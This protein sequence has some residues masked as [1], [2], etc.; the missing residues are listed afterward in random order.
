MVAKAERLAAN[1]IV[2]LIRADS[3]VESALDKIFRRHGLTGP[4][5]NVL[6]I[7]EGAHGPLSPYEIGDRLL[8]TRGTVTGL[9][10][11]LEGQG[12][13]RRTPHPRDRRMLLIETTA[14]SRAVLAR[15]RRELFPAQTKM[16]S[17]LTPREQVSLLRLLERLTAHLPAQGESAQGSLAK[18]R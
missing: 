7:L 16:V 18:A 8:V 6:M 12:L 4:S 2:S 1:V 13:V 5:F 15:A 10:D 9:L 3:L 11:T 17:A 14:K